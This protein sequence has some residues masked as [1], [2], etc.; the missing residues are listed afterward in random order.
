MDRHNEILA[1]GKDLNML[2]LWK[3]LEDVSRVAIV[4][5]HN[6]GMKEDI[7]FK[8]AI[9]HDIGKVS[10]LFQ[11]TLKPGFIRPPQ[12]IFRHEIAS[13]LFISLLPD[14]EKN[15]VIDMIIAHHKS[16]YQDINGMGFLDLDYNEESFEIHSKGFEQWSSIALDILSSFGFEVHK[17][18]LQEAKQNYEYG[19]DYC[20]KMRLN[21]SKWKGLLM[22]ADHLASAFSEKLSS[23]INKL[24]IIPDLTFY[25]RTSNLY[26]LSKISSTDNR[27]HTLVTA[28][29]GAGKTD[30]LL[31]R[32]KGRIFYVLPFQ[33][34]INA[35]YDRIKS[36]L[37]DTDA[38]IYLLHATSELKIDNGIVEER[39]MQRQIGA[40]IKILT[41]HQ[42]ASVVFGI[43]GYEAM[44][45][46]LYGCDIILDEIHTYSNTIQAIVLRLIDVLKN[47]NCKIHIGTATMS[48]ILHNKILDLLGGDENTYQV[49]LS[50][51]ILSTFNRHVIHKIKSFENCTEIIKNAVENKLK[52]LVVCNQ[53]KRSQQIYELLKEQYPNIMMMLVHSRFE[54]KRRHDLE[55]QLK[56][57]YNKTQNACIVVSTQVVEVSLDINFDILVTECAPI[58]AMIQRFGRINRKRNL[59]TI[60]KYK[61]IYVIAPPIEKNDC[62]PYDR[63]I[64]VKSYEVLP[65]DNLIEEIKIQDMLDKVYPKIDFINIDYSSVAFSEGQWVIKELCHRHKSALLDALDIDSAICIT[66]SNETQYIESDYN[67]RSKIEIPVSFRSIG[68]RNL[69]QLNCGSRP[70]VIPNNAYSDSLGV[71][72]DNI[73]PETYI[74]L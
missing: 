2:P 66:A 63:D 56:E 69:T 27:T 48:T 74:I 49:K 32:C 20:E 30:F 13:L 18:T 24:Y 41:P 33:A 42:I 57:V 59:D 12:F 62:L 7:A 31:R 53:V 6:L 71:L 50:D 52:I 25:N 29:T 35:M 38:Q 9:I 5:A 46:D 47:L 34:S 1:K 14:N 3:H 60:G 51:N 4:I 19:I 45:D 15:D 39:I 26:P 55:T 23:I 11:Q 58:D 17:I 67:E 61:P 54:R 73:K 28:P 72:I 65:S 44:A 70:F 22:S 40:S 43:K 16:L 36:D 10:P 8:G 64:L 21:Y 68:H 37:S